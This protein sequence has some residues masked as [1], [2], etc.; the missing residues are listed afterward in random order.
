MLAERPRPRCPMLHRGIRFV[1]AALS[2]FSA[3]LAF[4]FLRG[5]HENAPLGNSAPVDV[6]D[7]DDSVSASFAAERGV[8]VARDVTDLKNPDGVRNLHVASDGCYVVDIL[9]LGGVRVAVEAAAG[10][11]G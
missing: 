2:A 4:P 8:G 6:L 10:G 5:I 3:V 9:C 7:P 1:H 11:V